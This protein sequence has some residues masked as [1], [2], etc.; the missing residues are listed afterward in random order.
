MRGDYAEA[1]RII[2]DLNPS[3]TGRCLSGQGRFQRALA[4]YSERSA[5]IQKCV[6]LGSPLGSPQVDDID[7]SSPTMRCAAANRNRRR[8][9]WPAWQAEE[10]RRAA[11][12]STWRPPRR[13][14]DIAEEFGST[15]RV[16]T[17][18]D[19][20]RQDWFTAI[21]VAK[22]PP[23]ALSSMSAERHFSA[24][25][26]SDCRPSIANQFP[27]TPPA[28]DAHDEATINAARVTW[29]EPVRRSCGSSASKSP[30]GTN[31]AA[32]SPVRCMLGAQSMARCGAP[33]RSG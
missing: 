22:A 18:R 26:C 7:Q 16:M 20:S 2:P 32:A 15:H 8:L 24:C 17:A 12:M 19:V 3:Q 13:S 27:A 21:P 9:L 30:H 25:I 23:D 31:M 10:R 33:A 28:E 11:P 1:I 5:S 14:A 29:S 6:A 4:D